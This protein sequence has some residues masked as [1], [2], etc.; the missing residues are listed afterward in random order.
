LLLLRF[1]RLTIGHF[2]VMGL[3]SPVLRLSIPPQTS[4]AFHFNFGG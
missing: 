4:R 3:V 2:V 1:P